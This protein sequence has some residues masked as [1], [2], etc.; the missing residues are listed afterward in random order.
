M[1]TEDRSSV[2]RQM[3]RLCI[4]FALLFSWDACK[5]LFDMATSRHASAVGG[6]GQTRF[7]QALFLVALFAVLWLS[8]GKRPASGKSARRVSRPA[9]L[10]A[11][12]AAALVGVAGMVVSAILA[13]NLPPATPEFYEKLFVGHS[14]GLGAMLA[15][16]V[17]TLLR[18]GGL[19]VETSV[20][21]VVWGR[22]AALGV[23]AIA[24]YEIAKNLYAR[25]QGLNWDLAIPQEAIE[26]PYLWIALAA[27]SLF[28]RWLLRERD[29]NGL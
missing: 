14:L 23:V 8:F 6:A 18:Q 2:V 19:P 17:S 29:A 22:R 3:S 4:L 5:L 16:F 21:G 24:L 15:F 20:S 1:T 27:F 26:P 12:D 9:L 28:F 13:G 25:A 10:R 11:C 7:L